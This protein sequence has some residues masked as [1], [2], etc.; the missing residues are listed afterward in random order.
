MDWAGVGIIVGVQVA[1]LIYIFRR[2]DA[3][4]REISES[5]LQVQK[6]MLEFRKEVTAELAE[7]RKDSN[8]EFAKVR[9][10]IGDVKERIARLEGIIV[11]RQESGNGI[12]AQPGDD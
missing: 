3:M 1:T 5:R 12:I 9:E 11:G 4:Q 2:M 6:D 10:D 7:S 8:A